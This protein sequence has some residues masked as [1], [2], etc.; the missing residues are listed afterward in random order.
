MDSG[1]VRP[2]EPMLG[3]DERE[4][5]KAFYHN[6]A[7]RTGRVHIN[8]EKMK[9]C[10]AVL[11]WR[12]LDAPS[13]IPPIPPCSPPSHPVHGMPAA[14]L[15]ILKDRLALCV[16]TEGVN[17]VEKCE[18]VWLAGW[19]TWGARCAFRIACRRMRTRGARAS[20]PPPSLT[21]LRCH[22][23]FPRSWHGALRPACACASSMK[24]PT[25]GPAT[26]ATSSSASAC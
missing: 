17:H 2:T 6:A 10:G 19:H 8:L 22:F 7:Y 13:P 20:P 24:G 15:Q 16:R 4:D 12:L 21:Q 9:V 5:I 18:Q 26:W 11:D 14:P 3:V 1:A 23:P 25:S